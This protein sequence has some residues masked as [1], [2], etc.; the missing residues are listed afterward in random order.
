MIFTVQ[1]V[2]ADPPFSRIDFVSCRNLL[3]YLRPEAQAKV[4]MLFHFALRQGGILLLG[5]SETIGGDNDMFE[6]VSKTER[7]FRHIGYVRPGELDAIRSTVGGLR[8]PAR[9]GQGAAPSRHDGSG[10]F[11]PADGD[12]NLRARGGS[13]QPEERMPVFPWTDGPLSAGG[14]GHP[15]HDLLAMARPGLRTKLRSAI[16]RASLRTH[17]PSFRA[18]V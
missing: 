3:I 1:D 10:G 14:A 4:L 12:G 9:P 2:L 8:V 18:A 15:T 11:V 16:Q 17:G 6:V 7:I 5:T 13:D